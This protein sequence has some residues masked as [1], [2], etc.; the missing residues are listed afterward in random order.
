VI[1]DGN[2]LRC[3]IQPRELL[4]RATRLLPAFVLSAL[5]TAGCLTP[6]N[7]PVFAAK[8]SGDTKFLGIADQLSKTRS[9]DVLFV[10][11]RRSLHLIDSGEGQDHTPS[12]RTGAS[13]FRRP[14]CAPLT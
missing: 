13:M 11:G 9:L 12:R 7:T 14:L 3:A 6:Y 4:E 1:G 5:L 10:A 8:D 2:A